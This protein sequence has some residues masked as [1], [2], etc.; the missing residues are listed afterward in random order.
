MCRMCLM[1]CGVHASGGVVS[2]EVRAW[3]DS[4]RRSFLS[5][6]SLGDGTKTSPPPPASSRYPISQRRCSQN[7]STTFLFLALSLLGPR[8]LL[9]LRANLTCSADSPLVLQIPHPLL[10]PAPRRPLPLPLPLS[11]PPPPSLPS[12]PAVHPR[13]TDPSL[14]EAGG[15]V[16]PALLP[17]ASLADLSLPRAVAVARTACGQQALCALHFPSAS[18]ASQAARSEA[19]AVQAGLFRAGSDGAL[20][21]EAAGER[22]LG[23]GAK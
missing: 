6:A 15:L 16:V 17:R 3:L 23:G 18:A 14:R 2:G 13:C 11:F 19:R 9:P 8:H 5:G 1:A 21:R 10:D 22:G 7:Y 4:L 12:H 20:L